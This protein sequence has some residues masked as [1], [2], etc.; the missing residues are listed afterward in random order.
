MEQRKI[1]KSEKVE[2]IDMRCKLLVFP[3]VSRLDLEVAQ[4][5]AELIC[6][7]RSVII[8]Y[9]LSVLIHFQQRLIAVR[10]RER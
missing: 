7:A 1:I 2:Q 4:S 6:F 3:F 9:K 10:V 8:I 5:V